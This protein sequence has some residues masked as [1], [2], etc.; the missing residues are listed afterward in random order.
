MLRLVLKGKRARLLVFS[1]FVNIGDV[2]R[3]DILESSAAVFFDLLH[4]QS[5]VL[6]RHRDV[7]SNGTSC[8]QDDKH[9]AKYKMRSLK[10]AAELFVLLFKFIN[11]SS[12]PRLVTISLGKHLID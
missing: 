12:N 5:E 2:N 4:T 6:H 10:D 7:V 3:V 8:C 1:S 11:D 9:I